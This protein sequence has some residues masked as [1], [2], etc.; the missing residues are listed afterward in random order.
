MRNYSITSADSA[1]AV[2]RV[3]TAKALWLFERLRSIVRR[4]CPQESLLVNISLNYRK[5]S[6]FCAKFCFSLRK[7]K[8]APTD[9]DQHKHQVFYEKRK[10]H[11]FKIFS[12]KLISK[13]KTKDQKITFRIGQVRMT[14]VGGFFFNLVIPEKNF[15]KVLWHFDG[16]SNTLRFILKMLWPYLK[17]RSS[18]RSARTDERDLPGMKCL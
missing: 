3:S 10:C 2:I 18:L 8:T 4:L 11:L 12:L 9:H 14:W 13:A 15:S 16:V 7:E 6:T 1:F 5:I 17:Y